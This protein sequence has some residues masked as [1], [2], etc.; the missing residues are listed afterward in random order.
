MVRNILVI[1]LL[2]S[3]KAF[4]KKELVSIISIIPCNDTQPAIAYS[5]LTIE[6]CSKLTIKTPE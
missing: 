4:E 6:I 3:P 5:K 1:D 2:E